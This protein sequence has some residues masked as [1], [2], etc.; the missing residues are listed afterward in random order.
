[1]VGKVMAATNPTARFGK[2]ALVDRLAVGGMAE[3][4]LA[5]EETGSGP[6]RTIVLKRIRPHLTKV[7][8]FVKMF[9]NEARLAA[10]LNHPNIVQIHDL[11]KVADSYYIAMEYISG[12]DM[13]R[14][15]P[16]AAEMGIAF[17][18]V[19]ALKIASSVCQGLYYA[20]QKTDLAGSPL[21]LVHRDITPENI[22]VSFDGGVKIL[23]FGIAKA[24]NQLEQTR[25]GEIKG[26]LSYMSPEQASG[27]PLDARSDLFSLGVVL[28]E[29]LTG[30][31]LF[32]GE[33]EVAVLK[34][35]SD[36]RIH[37]PSY[38]RP[39]IPDEV[40]RIV[41]R[42]LEKDRD[43]R[44][45]SAWEFQQDLDRYLA[46]S[47]FTPSNL[48]LS[49][50][51]RQLFF[52]ELEKE[53]QRQGEKSGPETDE[54]ALDLAELAEEVKAAEARAREHA[55]AVEEKPWEEGD[56]PSESEPRGTEQLLALP[57]QAGDLKKL[58]QIATLHQTTPEALVREIL[59]S[60]L[61]YR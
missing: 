60:W 47:E 4:F 42:A 17:P 27:L 7:S 3:I 11:G 30:Y 29:W 19:Y 40:E 49:N 59:S 2:Y 33:S 54:Q 46:Q 28:Y 14:V 8:S 48:H 56:A 43:R 57:L 32:K 44:Y 58:G 52:D 50:F 22:L 21:E 24:S 26:K 37:A 34:T 10:Q 25:A 55:A 51:L 1:M 45:Q 36:G 39:E 18:L 53:K 6:A 9:L 41:M 23:D 15:I 5:R 16:R 61:K 20:H 38:F 12:R 13:R 31:R 35:I